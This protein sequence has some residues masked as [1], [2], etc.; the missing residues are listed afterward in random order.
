MQWPWRRDLQNRGHTKNLVAVLTQVTCSGVTDLLDCITPTRKRAS[1]ERQPHKTADPPSHSDLNRPDSDVINYRLTVLSVNS[2]IA[3][4]L[5]TLLCRTRRERK[6]HDRGIAC[7]LK[8]GSEL[9]IY[10]S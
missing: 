6:N 2:S 9:T 1:G 10:I 4:A 7:A 5:V 3:A 8:T